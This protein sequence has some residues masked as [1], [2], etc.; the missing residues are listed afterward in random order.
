MPIAEIVRSVPRRVP[1]ID[2]GVTDDDF[3]DRDP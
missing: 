2:R 3:P 1:E